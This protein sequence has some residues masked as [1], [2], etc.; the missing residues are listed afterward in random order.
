MC[1]SDLLMLEMA[2]SALPPQGWFIL[3]GPFNVN[4]TGTSHSNIQFN[5][6]LKSQNT[7]MG[8]RN[9]EDI[10]ENALQH[11]LS[12]MRIHDMPAHNKI[13]AFQRMLPLSSR[14]H[15]SEY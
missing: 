6:Y 10:E 7:Q 14:S 2:A 15:Q 5:R 4:N 9:I 12:L 11:D 3:Y 13:L 8:L 1:S